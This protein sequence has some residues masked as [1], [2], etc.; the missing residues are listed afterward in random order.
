ML[1]NSNKNHIWMLKRSLI[2]TS[3]YSPVYW[4]LLCVLGV[5]R[6]HR[7]AKPFDRIGGTWSRARGV[8]FASGATPSR[9]NT[10]NTFA[11]FIISARIGALLDSASAEKSAR[12]SMRA[13]RQSKQAPQFPAPLETQQ[14]QKTLLRSNSIMS[15]GRFACE[16]FECARSRLC[17]RGAPD[18]AQFAM[19]TSFLLLLSWR[20]NF[21]KA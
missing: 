12:R 3:L 18:A 1:L 21:A 7:I 11:R 19:Q 16:R 6:S 20:V 15:R 5:A 8:D 10:H 13:R 17:R 4:V 2:S 9:A 14:C